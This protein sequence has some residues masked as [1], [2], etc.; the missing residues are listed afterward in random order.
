MTAL[1]TEASVYSTTVCT[2]HRVCIPCLCC[3]PYQ[4][5]PSMLLKR[6]SQE[7]DRSLGSGVSC[8]HQRRSIISTGLLVHEQ[9]LCS[10]K[11][12]A[13]IVITNGYPTEHWDPCSKV[14]SILSQRCR[15]LVW[16]LTTCQTLASDCYDF[17]YVVN[18]FG[19]I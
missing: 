16:Y 9:Y 15:R 6:S 14:S 10:P 2:P 4:L 1:S 17:G 18:R 8:H 12:N 3:P 11:W 7:V 19:L 5:P 13:S